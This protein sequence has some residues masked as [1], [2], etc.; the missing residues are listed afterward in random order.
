MTL[1]PLISD[2]TGT[3]VQTL[4]GWITD[5]GQLSIFGTPPGAAPMLSHETAKAWCAE[6]SQTCKISAPGATDA[7]PR[8][9]QD[10]VW[11]ILDNCRKI[12]TQRHRRSALGQHP[13]LRRVELR[14][15]RSRRWWSAVLFRRLPAADH[16]KPAVVLHRSEP[17][18]LVT[19]PPGPW[20]LEP[21]CASMPSRCV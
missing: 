4:Q 11:R 3:P 20:P 8:N 18:Q 2:A 15:Q 7:Q 13:A 9:R 14:Q 10:V 19:L 12:A 6:F 16:G 21:V 5:F 1:P 17:L